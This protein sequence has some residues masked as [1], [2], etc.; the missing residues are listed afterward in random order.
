[1]Y[2]VKIPHDRVAVVIGKNGETKKQLE[3]VTKTNIDVDSKEG[4]VIIEGEDSLN[5]FIAK[6]M[7]I[8]IG[9]GINPEIAQLLIKQDYGFDIINIMDYARTKKDMIRLKGRVIGREGR[10]RKTI[11]DLTECNI[12]VYGKTIGIVGEIEKIGIAR[13]AIESLLT[14]SPHSKVYHWL[15]RQRIK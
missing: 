8:A 12:S 10:S 1:M 5:L 3:I 11:E 14:G 6:E 7:I 15:E 2:N 9:R 4:E 13:R